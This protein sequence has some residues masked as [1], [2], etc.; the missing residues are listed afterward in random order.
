MAVEAS[1]SATRIKDEARRGAEARRIAAHC[2]S[3]GISV[4]GDVP[5]HVRRYCIENNVPLAEMEGRI[6]KNGERIGYAQL[7]GDRFTDN[8]ICNVLRRAGATV[9]RNEKEMSIEITWKAG[10]AEAKRTDRIE[11][12]KKS[13]SKFLPADGPIEQVS[14]QITDALLSEVDRQLRD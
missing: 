6:G 9:V 2:L 13:R 4:P 7:S 8:E 10:D 11:R 5:E 3:A 12:H 14:G 1:P